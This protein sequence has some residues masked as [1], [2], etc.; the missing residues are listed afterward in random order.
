MDAEQSQKK[1]LSLQAEMKGLSK[2]EQSMRASI[3]T[4][5]G[6]SLTYMVYILDSCL[7]CQI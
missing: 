6:K 3:A 4:V 2:M 5:D 7:Y 1:Y